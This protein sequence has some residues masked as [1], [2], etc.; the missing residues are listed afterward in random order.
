MS[1][2]I[3]APIGGIPTAR[4]RRELADPIA[5][6]VERVGI[7]APLRTGVR[8]AY[9]LVRRTLRITVGLAG[10]ALL[11]LVFLRWVVIPAGWPTTS[12]A[13]LQ[14]PLVVVRADADGDVELGCQ[15]GDLVEP[16]AR[17]ATIANGNV[18]PARVAHLK[19]ALAT[20]DAEQAKFGKDLESAL[21]FD[22]LS[23]G[24]LAAYRQT[25]VAGLKLSLLEA[26][27]QVAE[28]VVAH[29]Q[30]R[31]LVDLTRRTAATGATSEDER[32]RAVEAESIAR[33][34]RPRPVED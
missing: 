18:D 23:S 34:R 17:V 12:E 24:E 4:R 8:F 2:Q 27:A 26:E 19:S 13:W 11:L 9:Q 1:S 7:L 10:V 5:E 30:A 29:D 16:G 14:A 31:R 15:D 25:L 6:D 3:A 32:E 33:P 28:C 22:R 20:V 21:S